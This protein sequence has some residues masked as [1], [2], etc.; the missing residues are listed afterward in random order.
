MLLYLTIFLFFYYGACQAVYAG[1]ED[2][3]G[4]RFRDCA[5]V[6]AVAAQVR[7]HDPYSN[8]YDGKKCGYFHLYLPLYC[9]MFKRNLVL[10]FRWNNDEYF[11]RCRV[12]LRQSHKVTK[13]KTCNFRLMIKH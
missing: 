8:K 5:A 11:K 3:H 7:C 1:A 10:C 6:E 9:V 12:T 4:D 2:E 13:K